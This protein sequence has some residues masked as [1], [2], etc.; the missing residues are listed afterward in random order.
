MARRRRS[1]CPPQTIDVGGAADTARGLEDG[2]IEQ[3]TIIGQRCP[4][5]CRPLLSCTARLNTDLRAT[6]TV[7]MLVDGSGHVTKSRV[8]AP[9][10]LQ[11]NGSP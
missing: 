1:R 10:Y 2:E 6:I 5:A 8:Q 7:K 4:A 3:S 11:D 9:H